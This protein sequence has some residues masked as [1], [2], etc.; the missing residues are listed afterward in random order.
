MNLSSNSSF[1]L[2]PEAFF[3]VDIEFYHPPVEG[4][5]PIVRRSSI[6]IELLA[7]SVAIGSLWQYRRLL[8]ADCSA[9]RHHRQR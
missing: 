8:V 3:D 4:L 6:Q 5:E 7:E 1:Q 2:S 9:L